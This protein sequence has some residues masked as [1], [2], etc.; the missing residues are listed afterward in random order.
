[1]GISCNHYQEGKTLVG[2]PNFFVDPTLTNNSGQ[3]VDVHTNSAIYYT[4][5]ELTKTRPQWRFVAADAARGTTHNILTCV[6]IYEDSDMLGFV[7][8]E[9]KGRSYKLRVENDRINAKRERGNGY[10]TENTAKA[11]LAIRK[12]FFKAADDERLNKARS[13]AV[14]V[15]YDQTNK[16]RHIR[17][18]SA[19]AVFQDLRK[20]A[21]SRLLDYLE[22]SG[23]HKEHD[24]YLADKAEHEVTVDVQKALD[25]NNS[26]LIVLDGTRCLMKDDKEGVTILNDGEMPYDI[27]MKLGLLK[28]VQ[29]K[30]MVSNVGCRVDEHTFV[31]LREKEQS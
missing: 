27:R 25:K 22:F 9:W 19:D 18:N 15:V 2:R 1:M 20:F 31:L 29:D 24:K 7:D 12:N 17:Q 4:L 5:D 10:F 16:K 21:D 28:L 13:L 26:I 11:A 8:V 23:K 30:Q 6:R 3:A 14:S